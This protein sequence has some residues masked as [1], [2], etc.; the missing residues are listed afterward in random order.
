MFGNILFAKIIILF[1]FFLFLF[2]NFTIKSEVNK[3]Y[4]S[5]NE[6]IVYNIIFEQEGRVNFPNINLPSIENWQVLGHSFSSGTKII[7]NYVQSNKTQT[8]RLL[9]LKEGKLTIPSFTVEIDGKKYT[10]NEHLIV[11]TSNG[12][13]VSNIQQ[14]NLP[15]TFL[16]STTNKDV[17]FLNEPII[18]KILFYY[19]Q[20]I[21]SLSDISMPNFVNLNNIES[22]QNNQKQYQVNLNGRNYNVL[23]FVSVLKPA[24]IGDAEI[25]NVRIGYTSSPFSRMQYVNS[26]KLKLSNI[27]IDL[28][29]Q[30]SA[31]GDYEINA[32]ISSSKTDINKGIYLTISIQ[33]KGD[34]TISQLPKFNVSDRIEVFEPEMNLKRELRDNYLWSEKIFSYLLIPRKDGNFTIRDIEFTFFSPESKSI[35]KITTSNLKIFVNKTN[36]VNNFVENEHYQEKDIAYIHN[37]TISTYLPYNFLLY[38]VALVI[39]FILTIFF[40]YFVFIS[41]FRSIFESYII[42]TKIK[43]LIYNPK[44]NNA[45]KINDIYFLLKKYLDFFSYEYT[46]EIQDILF[47]FET[48]KYSN[49]YDNIEYTELVNKFFVVLKNTP[50]NKQ[51]KKGLL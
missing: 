13:L 7:N 21:Y 2:A 41:F 29:P 50:K 51:N 48:S 33:G 1:S 36:I 23:E 25:G 26:E 24:N 5:I 10:T 46:K 17:Y 8:Y 38:T 22:I 47:L 3:M 4:T 40:I 12:N 30:S 6:P 39:L 42:R 37:I 14:Q 45:T 35:Q 20:N 15:S 32:K 49:N 19:S 28:I 31:V 11:V 44:L 18:Y 34:L 27:K 43:K 9:P 16:V